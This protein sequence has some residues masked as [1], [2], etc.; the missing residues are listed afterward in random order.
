MGAS[1]R[2]R[3][4]GAPDGGGRARP[5]GRALPPTLYGQGEEGA[6]ALSRPSALLAQA[7]VRPT[8]SRGQNFLT[9]PAIADRI[10]AAADLKP[11]DEVIEIGP[12]LG[13]LSDRI[14]QHSIRRLCLIELDSRLAL[15]LKE[16]LREASNLEIVEADVLEIDLAASIQRPP[17]KIVGNLPFNVAAAI[18]RKLSDYRQLI[19]RMVLMFQ[20]EVAARIRAQVGDPDYAALSVY[21]ALDWEIK[22]HFRVDS[23]SFH[24]RPKVDAEVLTFVP[25]AD[26]LY[27]VHERRRVLDTI[28][29][30]FSSPRKMIRNNLSAALKLTA[31]QVQ[32]ALDS[33]TIDPRARAE[34][35][36]AFDFVRLARSLERAPDA[37]S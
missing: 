8:K 10:V 35:L 36:S 25:R 37:Q 34:A 15:Q 18:L 24:P 11:D 9:Q 17:V 3:T 31:A 22:R 28:R 19:S 33:A 27:V 26:Q 20:R 16:R 29:A 1:R 32:A 6:A 7:G 14:L 13:F 30:G 2:R 5:K 23:G 12:G 21:T 4:S